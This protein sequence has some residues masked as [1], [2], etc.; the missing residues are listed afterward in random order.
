M[1]LARWTIACTLGELLGFGVGGA[2]G[3]SAF[4]AIPDPTT[5]PLAAMLVLAC[6]I[7]GLIEGAVL[8]G[9][10][11]LALRTTYRSLPARAWI[12]TTALAGATGWLLGSLPPTLVSL[13]GAPTTG[14]A[15]AWDPDL[16]TTV[17]VSAALG[18]VLGAMFGAF[19]WLALRRHASGAARWIAGNA[20]AWAL[21][22]PWSYVA[23][24]MASAATRPDVMIAIVAGTG[25]MMGATV[26]L[27]SGLFLRRIAP[28]TRERSLQ[29]G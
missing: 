11:W 15:P 14:D 28:R 8:G 12:A 5:L 16:V 27:V 3:A 6:V 18:A 23:G 17:L 24:G 10:Q 21:A 4:I 29:V 1:P 25:V 22:L 2:L 13:L 9:M 20:C 19:Q 26:A 7:A